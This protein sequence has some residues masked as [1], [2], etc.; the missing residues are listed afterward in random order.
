M[1]ITAVAVAA[2]AMLAGDVSRTGKHKRC[3]RRFYRAD[4]LT[5]TYW[6]GTWYLW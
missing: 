3:E 6:S 5:K 4:F 1:P 2:A